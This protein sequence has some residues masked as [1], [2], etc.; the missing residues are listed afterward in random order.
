MSQFAMTDNANEGLEL[1][2]RE[3]LASMVQA[4]GRKIDID[5]LNSM[6]AADVDHDSKINLMEVYN[7]VEKEVRVAKAVVHRNKL[8]MVLVR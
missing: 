3:E 4:S 8:I 2:P 7:I 5:A 6:Y 1:L